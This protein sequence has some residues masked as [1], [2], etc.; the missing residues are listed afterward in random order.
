MKITI[1]LLKYIKK[2]LFFFIFGSFILITANFINKY[3]LFYIQKIIDEV[4]NPLNLNLNL[5]Q[6]LLIDFSLKYLT[7]LIIS[8]IMMYLGQYFLNICSLKIT[9]FLREKAYYV[10]NKLPISYFD[11]NSAGKIASKVVGDIETLRINFYSQLLLKFL[12]WVINILTIIV[13]SFYLNKLLLILYFALIP[14]YIIIFKIYNKNTSEPI[15]ELFENTS[16]QN[17]LINE[18]VFGNEIIKVFNQQ[19]KVISGFEK[20]LNRNLYLSS[21]WIKFDSC[22]SWSMQELLKQFAIAFVIAVISYYIFGFNNAIS[23]GIIFIYIKYT[24]EYVLVL[25]QILRLLPVIRRSL[26]SGMRVLDFIESEIEKDLDSTLEIN[27]ADVEFK[28]VSF[29]YVKETA[30]L[31]NISFKVNYG[32]SIA[33]VGHTGSGKSSIVNLLFKFYRVKKGEILI[34]GKNIDEY[35]SESV[36]KHMGIVLQDPYIFKGTIA[37]NVSMGN[38]NISESEITDALIKVGAQTMISKFEKGIYHELAEKGNT[39][40]SGE[41]QLISF[42]RALV[43]NPKILILDEATSHIDSETELI[44]QKALEVVKKGRTTL[45]IA[46]RLSTIQNV[47]KIIVLK[48]GEIIETGNHNQLVKDENSLYYE[49]FKLQNK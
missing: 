6:K 31:K 24:E 20:N 21:K 14:I 13:I 37:S 48:N 18:A 17:S 42:A 28:N 26:T 30:V 5:N 11:N 22:F 36:R 47:D 45:I 44:I 8:L 4:I 38:N 35:N 19:E 2:S 1:K 41:R 25:S 49:M 39:L 23:V 9:S 46:H 10:L 33:L 12:Q 15:K 27:Q 3:S 32:E 34:D 7:L 43:F 40:S 16:N 29:E